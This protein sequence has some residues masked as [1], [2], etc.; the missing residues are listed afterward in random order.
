MS[1][2]TE[3]GAEPPS[4]QHLI[5]SRSGATLWVSLNR[6]EVKNALN[7]KIIQELDQMVQWVEPMLDIRI[8]VLQGSDGNFCAG[9]DVREMF[10]AKKEFRARSFRV[11]AFRG[12]SS[13]FIS[14]FLFPA[15]A[16]LTQKRELFSVQI[17]E[18]KR[19]HNS[20]STNFQVRAKG[21]L[22][23]VVV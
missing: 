20:N 10:R 5:L 16:I 4:F 13:P 15:R 9:G 6:P 7:R 19:L 14:L 18:K 21:I 3:L 1:D 8:V 12:N 17:E 11:F 2:V 23:V 22:R